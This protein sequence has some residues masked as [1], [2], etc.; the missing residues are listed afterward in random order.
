MHPQPQHQLLRGRGRRRL[1][2]AAI[3][4]VAAGCGLTISGGDDPEG[5]GTRLTVSVTNVGDGFGSVDIAFPL[6]TG[7][8]DPCPAV[9]GPGASCSPFVFLRELPQ[10][11][12]V[13]AHSEP[14]SRFTGWTGSHC[15][16]ASTECDAVVESGTDESLVVLAPRFDLEGGG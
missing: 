3:L 4:V 7:V 15:S 10:F 2:P 14:G 1:A 5:P 12:S 8:G 13:E 9:L 16:G 11:V 6:G